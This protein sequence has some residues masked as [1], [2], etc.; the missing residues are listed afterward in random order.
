MTDGAPQFIEFVKN[1]LIRKMEHDYSVDTT[2]YGRV[3]LGHSF[4]GLF[5]AYAFGVQNKLFG[6]YILLSP[7]ISYDNEVVL[8]F[9]KDNRNANQ[10]RKQLVCMG[11][12]ELENSGRLQAPFEAF[13]QI[14]VR[15]YPDIQVAKNQEKDLDHVGSKNPNMVLGL[16]YYFKHRSF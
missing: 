6:N 9:E 16:R 4:G 14:L 3:V 1:Q 5:G 11:L 12:G 8:K 2:R 10:A 13:Y 7:S 15:N